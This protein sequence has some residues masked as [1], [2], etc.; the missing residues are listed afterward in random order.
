MQEDKVDTDVN[1]DSQKK[2]SKTEFR[3]VVDHLEMELAMKMENFDVADT[4]RAAESLL[5][6][7]DPERKAEHEKALI[8]DAMASTYF[9]GGRA[10]GDFE[11]RL[12]QALLHTAATTVTLSLSLSL[13]LSI[14]LSISLYR[15]LSAINHLS[16]TS[17]IT[18]HSF[19]FI[20]QLTHSGSSYV[21]SG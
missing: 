15:S 10:S 4:I 5:Y 1:S 20:H 11:R 3:S 9:T 18:Y 2:R 21:T 14:S 17:S 8:F 13:S 6:R 12:Q 19:E 7:L 16:L